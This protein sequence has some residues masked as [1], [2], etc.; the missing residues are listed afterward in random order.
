[1][2]NLFKKTYT[3]EEILVKNLMTELKILHN[4]NP[5]QYLA[6]P[7]SLS[8][9]ND[10]KKTL[11]YIFANSRLYVDDEEKLT[12]K[13]RDLDLNKYCYMFNGSPKNFIELEKYEFLN[14]NLIVFKAFFEEALK[15]KKAQYGIGI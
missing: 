10:L 13:E 2:L 5:F 12:G 14:S 3:Y 11:I 6:V 7:L 9:T 1:M 8:L 15:T 4:R